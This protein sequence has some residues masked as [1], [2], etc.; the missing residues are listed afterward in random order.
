[1]DYYRDPRTGELLA[2]DRARI[3]WTELR[4]DPTTKY[5]ARWV[6]TAPPADPGRLTSVSQSEADQ[7]RRE[8]D[9]A[10]AAA[11]GALF[12]HQRFQRNPTEFL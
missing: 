1:M 4:C 10:N 11:R 6:D 2:F 8:A 5:R 9:E 12:L 3:T 7:Y